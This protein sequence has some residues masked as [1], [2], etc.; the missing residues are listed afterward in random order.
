M[1]R[2]RPKCPMCAAVLEDRNGGFTKVSVLTE[3]WERSTLASTRPMSDVAI[4]TRLMSAV[5]NDYCYVFNVAHPPEHH[6]ILSSVFHNMYRLFPVQTRIVVGGAA[7]FLRCFETSIDTE[8]SPQWRRT[9]LQDRSV[10]ELRRLMRRPKFLPHMR[11][12]TTLNIQDLMRK[13]VR[14]LNKAATPPQQPPPP[15][16]SVVHPILRRRRRRRGPLVGTSGEPPSRRSLHRMAMDAAAMARENSVRMAIRQSPTRQSPIGAEPTP[17]A[18]ANSQ[19][20]P[21]GSD[22]DSSSASFA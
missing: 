17:A 2:Q 8:V 12:C 3:W 10:V 22:S 6:P 5:F 1:R 16:M 15:M 4:A 9:L 14:Y 20:P 13:I 11:V 19:A 18:A 7:S 21:D